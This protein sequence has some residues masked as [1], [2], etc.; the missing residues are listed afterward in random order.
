MQIEK[1]YKAQAIRK[2]ITEL[3]SVSTGLDSASIDLKVLEKLPP[4][5]RQDLLKKSAELIKR[6]LTKLIR[7]KEK[8]FNDL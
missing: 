2:E 1:F 5:M 8:E 3:E 4:A 7:A 6:E